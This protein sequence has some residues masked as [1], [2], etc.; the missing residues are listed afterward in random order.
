MALYA[1]GDTHLSFSTNKPMDIFGNNWTDH[2][3]RLEKGFSQLNDDD[4]CV[5]CG[6]ISW[7][8]S[9]EAAEDDF[10]FIDSLPGKTKYV[11]K[12]NHDYWWTTAAKMNAFFERTGIN[13]IKILHNNFYCYGE[14]AICGTRGW[15]YEEETH[16]GH[17]KKIMTRELIR[18]E[19]SLKLAGDVEKLCFLHYPPR[20]GNYTCVPILELFEKYGVKTCC[21][22]HIHGAGH[23]YAVTGIID[24]TD[25]KMVSADYLGFKPIKILP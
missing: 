3:H 1:I 21:Y 18:L 6:D 12:G 23:R 2:V 10:K 8:M 7:A 24:N 25:Y 13:T 5:I 4:E 17:D 11:L 19:T 20:F 16:G 15:F 14:Y 22:G 9:L